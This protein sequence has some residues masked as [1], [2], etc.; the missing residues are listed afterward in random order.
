MSA[1]LEG[2]VCA[3][4]V[5]IEQG[6]VP[7]SPLDAGVRYQRERSGFE[8]WNIASIV[9]RLGWGDCE[10][11]NGWAAAGL[12]YTG[13]DAGAQAYLYESAPHLFHC[14]CLLSSGE[15]YDVCPA[16]GMRSRSSNHRLPGRK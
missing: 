7:P 4:V 9:V 13:E 14:V 16:L 12:R 6:I 1:F 15:I 5:L 2:L 3:N 10:D 8:E 11:L